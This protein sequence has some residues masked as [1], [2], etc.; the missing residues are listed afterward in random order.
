MHSGNLVEFLPGFEVPIGAELDAYIQSY[1]C[2]D[3]LF[4]VNNNAPNS[5]ANSEPK[6]GLPNL[7]FNY[8]EPINKR[9]DAKINSFLLYP[10]PNQGKF[11]YVNVNESEATSQLIICD[12]AGKAVYTAYINNNAPFELDL[13]NL[14][15]GLYIVKVINK[16]SSDNFKLNIVR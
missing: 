16:N 13:S 12:I 9:P 7:G 10:N 14:N 4:R 2:A 6:H 8:D 15:N 5:N 1:N 11:T 3:L